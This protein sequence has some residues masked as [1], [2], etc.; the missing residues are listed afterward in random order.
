MNPKDFSSFMDWYHTHYLILNSNKIGIKGHSTHIARNQAITHINTKTT[1]E[2]HSKK[3]DI[4]IHAATALQEPIA[5]DDEYLTSCEG[6]PP[7]RKYFAALLKTREPWADEYRNTWPKDQ[8]I[9]QAYLKSVE[10]DHL[11]GWAKEITRAVN[12]TR[13]YSGPVMG[14]DEFLGLKEWNGN[15][16]G[17]N[18]GDEN[19]ERKNA[20]IAA[21]ASSNSESGSESYKPQYASGRAYFAELLK[22]REVWAGEYQPTWTMDR[23]IEQAYL[24]S[25]Q[26]DL[27]GRWAKETN[28]ALENG[29]NL[30]C[31]NGPSMDENEFAGLVEWDGSDAGRD[32]GRLKWERQCAVI[33][34]WGC[35]ELWRN[36]DEM[37]VESVTGFTEGGEKVQ[38]SMRGETFKATEQRE[39][40]KPT[41]ADS[42]AFKISEQG[43]QQ[44]LNDDP[45]AFQTVEEGDSESSGF[46]T[47]E[48]QQVVVN[49]E[50]IGWFSAGEE[51]YEFRKAGAV[52]QMVEKTISAGEWDAVFNDDHGMSIAKQTAGRA[53]SIGEWD[54]VFNDVCEMGAEGRRGEGSIFL[55]GM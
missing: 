9:E 41:R 44:G 7:N 18:F 3:C 21:W 52:R 37:D 49:H 55:S 39:P 11:G 45:T 27:S 53:I 34:G 51:K 8:E 40:E 30:A 26:D 12:N 35:R 46:E 16:T 23:S 31:Y 54:E 19:M 43:K 4:F 36:G 20:M 48:N 25:V 33:A 2:E 5:N 1:S 32:F 13:N 17:S 29:G 22:T 47:V 42:T 38:I 15:E 6:S 28:Y 10:D 14:E 50:F 24:Q